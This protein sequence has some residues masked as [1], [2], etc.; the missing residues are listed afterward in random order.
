LRVAGTGPLEEALKAMPGAE[1]V[2]W[3]GMLDRQALAEHLRGVRALV[4]PSEW[5]E[6]APM[7]V[8]EAFASG[9]P[10]IGSRIGGIPE[11]IDDDTGWLFEPGDAEDLAAVLRRVM[12]C[13]DS[14]IVA[15]GRHSRERVAREFNRDLHRARV[16][17]VYRELG[18]SC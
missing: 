4:L 17:E 11:L 9:V 16:L 8:L 5:Y 15:M 7:S 3:L 10:V 2:R 6:N 14:R 1:R 18:V 12:S 13:S